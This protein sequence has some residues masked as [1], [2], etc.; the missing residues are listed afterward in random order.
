MVWSTRPDQE[1]P[2]LMV[3]MNNGGGIS[4]AASTR[5]GEQRIV[6]RAEAFGIP[7]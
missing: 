3:V 5:H 2:V 4:T 7:G 6:D 1:L